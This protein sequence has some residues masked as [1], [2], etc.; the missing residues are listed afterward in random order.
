MSTISL[1]YTTIGNHEDAERLAKTIIENKLAG[2][3]NLVPIQSM[4][5]WNTTVQDDKEVG[6]I[7]KTTEEKLPSLRE[8]ITI[9]HPY[10]IPCILEF[11]KV[12]SN[13]A[14]GHWIESQCK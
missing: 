3:V 12:I 11:P 10:E 5:Q 2:C 4:Y 6:L 14:Y 13:E 1:I 8:Y 9:H 7:I